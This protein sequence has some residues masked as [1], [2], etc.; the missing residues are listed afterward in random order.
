[1]LF[2]KGCNLLCP[3]CHNGSLVVRD[4]QPQIDPDEVIS[5]LKKRRGLI[6]GVVI[7]GGEPTLYPN[8]PELID[9]I[10]ELG[11]DVKLDSNGLQ[12]EKLKN[13][14]IDY[15]ALDIKTS[16]AQYERML[17]AKSPVKESLLQS[18][19]ILKSYGDNGE[20]RITTAPKIVTREIIEELA[21]YLEGVNK[22]FLQPF[23]W[24]ETILNPSL[25]AHE[26]NYESEEL[27]EFAEIIG[28]YTKSC[29]VRGA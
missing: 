5:F 16:F 19:E 17:G 6:E 9:F 1:M 28:K 25:L 8:L 21:P 14:N 23:K 2:F 3:Y 10:K 29:L 11:Y 22:V 12:P 27:F 4:D 20:V 26:R 7:S 15:L 13:L 18:L 24:S